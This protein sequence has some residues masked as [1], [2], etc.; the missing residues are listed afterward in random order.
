MEEMKWAVPNI[1]T[2]IISVAY[3]QSRRLHDLAKRIAN[4][5]DTNLADVVLP[6]YVDN[7]GVARFW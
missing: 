6:D 5:S 2:R 3:R 4:L 7:D 1:D